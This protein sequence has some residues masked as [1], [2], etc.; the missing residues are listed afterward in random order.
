[1]ARG[2]DETNEVADAHAAAVA[3]AEYAA[4]VLSLEEYPTCP[5]RG[6]GKVDGILWPYNERAPDP[7]ELGCAIEVQKH[8]GSWHNIPT[9]S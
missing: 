5:W 6:N 3:S 8:L 9:A 7:S 2:E 1:M 4:R